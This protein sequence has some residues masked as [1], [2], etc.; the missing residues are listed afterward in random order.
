M[1]H[2]RIHSLCAS[3]TKKKKTTR[4]RLCFWAMREHR[5]QTKLASLSNPAPFHANLRFLPPLLPPGYEDAV[6]LSLPRYLGFEPPLTSLY[7]SPLPT[8]HIEYLPPIN[9]FSSANP[10]AYTP[11]NWSAEL[12]FALP[13]PTL[14]FD[15]LSEQCGPLTIRRRHRYRSLWREADE[16]AASIVTT[17]S[18]SVVAGGAAVGDIRFL[19]DD[20]LSLRYLPVSGPK[21]LPPTN[22]VYPGL[23]S[24]FAPFPA[25]QH[26][27]PPSSIITATAVRPH[28]EVMTREKAGRRV[29]FVNVPGAPLTSVA[30]AQALHRWGE[31]PS[32]AVPQAWS[33]LGVV[34]GFRR[35]LMAQSMRRAQLGLETMPPRNVNYLRCGTGEDVIGEA[36]ERSGQHGELSG[37]HPAPSSH[38]SRRRSFFT[39]IA[40]GMPVASVTAAPQVRSGRGIS[41]SYS[42]PQTSALQT[43]VTPPRLLR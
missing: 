1:I 11:L 13:H 20:L 12:Q 21:R 43:V 19:D 2:S 36:L 7:L 6:P 17:P 16:A 42:L 26:Q 38:Y 35:P 34:P 5:Y 41:P 8:S 40:S 18:G 33:D 14:P 39:G 25:G 3:T 27:L 37:L 9:P 23:T 10:S 30:D 24:P 28:T 15:S 31:S 4:Q 32:P 29:R 22:F